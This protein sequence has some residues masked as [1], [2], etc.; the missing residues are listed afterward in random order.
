MMWLRSSLMLKAINAVQ[1]IAASFRPDLNRDNFQ[2][3]KVEQLPYQDHLFDLI[4]SS[5]VL[6][7]AN[8]QQ[9]FFSMFQEMTRCLKRGGILF[10]RMASDI[11]IEDRVIHQGSG[12]YSLPD[13]ST[14]FLLTRSLIGQLEQRFSIDYLEP[15]KTVNV[16]DQRCMS[17]LVVTLQQ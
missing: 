11:G 4:I 5:A 7:F 8:N 10:M 16:N 15:F 1:F 6:H 2:V 12:R 3:G 17:T 9:H 14:R 13:G